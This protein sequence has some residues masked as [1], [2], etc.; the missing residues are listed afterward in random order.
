MTLAEGFLES[1]RIYIPGILMTKPQSLDQI[2]IR[3]SHK[4]KRAIF[5]SLTNINL[6]EV[7][8]S[9]EKVRKGLKIAQKLESRVHVASI[10]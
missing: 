2:P 4:P 10:T 7:P 1:G 3:T 8:V 9:Q 5:I 6:S